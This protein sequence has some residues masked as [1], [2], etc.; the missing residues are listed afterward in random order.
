MRRL[1][2]TQRML[3]QFSRENDRLSSENGRLR[4]GKNLV[5]NDYKGG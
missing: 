3:V 2:E 1:L 5:A 4:T